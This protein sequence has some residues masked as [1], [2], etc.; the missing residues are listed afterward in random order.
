MKLDQATGK[1]EKLMYARVLLEIR[2]ER[3]FPNVV[4]FIN[5][6]DQ[7]MNVKVEYE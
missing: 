7:R 1:R 3:K 2:L 6:K 4:S 5:E